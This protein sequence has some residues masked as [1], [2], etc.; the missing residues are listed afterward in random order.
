M[1]LI[2]YIQRSKQCWRFWRYATD[3]DALIAMYVEDIE[4]GVCSFYTTL[5]TDLLIL[6]LMSKVL[7]VSNTM[8]NW[9]KVQNT[10]KHVFAHDFLN[11][12]LIFNPQ[13]VLKSWDLGLSNHTIKYCVYQSMFKMSRIDQIHLRVVIL[14]MSKMSKMGKA[15]THTFLLITSSIFN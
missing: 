11:I 4:E 3:F 1:H 8:N 12:Q 15:H 2:V 10:Y 14:C 6:L 9:S 13:K 7:K 5:H